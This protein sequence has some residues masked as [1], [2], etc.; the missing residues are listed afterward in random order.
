ML[1]QLRP[2]IRIRHHHHRLM[3]RLG[4]GDS[5]LPHNI[6]R[7]ELYA[8]LNEGEADKLSAPRDVSSERH[9]ASPAPWQN[10]IPYPRFIVTARTSNPADARQYHN[11]RLEPCEQ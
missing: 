1:D 3:T 8:A 7:Q 9:L 4:D 6:S 2:R 10:S 5:E 11:Q